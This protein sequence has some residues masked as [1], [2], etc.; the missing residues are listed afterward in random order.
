MSRKLSAL[1][2]SVPGLFFVVVPTAVD[3]FGPVLY[4]ACAR[5]IAGHL[6]YL[7]VEQAMNRGSCTPV[8]SFPTA[9][10]LGR[11]DADAPKLKILVIA[12]R[13][14]PIAVRISMALADVG[15]RVAALTPHGHPMRRSRKIQDHFAYHTRPQLKSTI[16][17]IDRW[18]PDLLVCADDRAVGE[19]QTLH[20]RTAASDDK[21]R[22][23][24]SKLIELSIGPATSFAAM[25]NKS[26]FLARV[27]IEGLRFPRT[28]VIPATRTFESVPELIYPIVVKADQSYGGRCVRIIN[29]DADVRATVWELQTPTTWRGRRFFGMILGSEALA[30]L[31]LSLR[32]TI[33]LQQYIP[34]RPSNRA[35]ICWKG[36]VLAGISV[37][38]VE[39]T[40]EYGPASVVRLIDHPEMAMVAE[41]M[42]EC[43]NLSGFVGFDFVLDSSN[44]AWLIEM[45]PRVTPISHFSLANGTTLAGSLYRQMTGLRPPSKLAPINRGLI[46]LFPDEIVRSPSSE[47]LQSCQHDVPWNEPEVVSSVLNQALQTG[48]LRRVRTF[49]GRY[50]PTLV[51]ALIRF[52]L[53]DPC[54]DT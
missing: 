52:G 24:I 10:N 20:Q 53:A 36:K 27:E 54:G 15:F 12:T 19:L 41:H 16:R 9:T 7:S 35:V 25:V 21:V 29:S 3:S 32:R 13:K 49:L 46:A 38:V 39:L 34:G 22:R 37:E 18:S 30:P 33:S 1:E 17:A 8:R 43:L 45:N 50:F 51:N 11:A 42:V 2:S 48:I 5:F 4:F 14:T 40:H 44:Q 47:Y 26:E 31:M 28:I 6:S 23:H